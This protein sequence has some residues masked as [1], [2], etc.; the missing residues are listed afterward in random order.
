M[1]NTRV[2][3]FAVT[4]A[5]LTPETLAFAQQPSAHSK[6]AQAEAGGRFRKG[7]E[8]FD[9]GDY[10]AALIEFRRAYEIAPNFAVLYNIGQVYYLLQ[11]Y[12]NALNT[13]ERYLSEGD[14]SIQLARRRDVQKEIQKL[15]SRVASLDITV[16]VPDADVTIDD[17]TVGKSPLAKPVVVNPGRHRIA[18][19]KAGFNSTSKSI[20]VAS[21]D[22]PKL[23][24]ELTEQAKPTTPALPTA[25]PSLQG[26]GQ[27]A[28]A[29]GEVTVPPPPPGGGEVVPPSPPPP[30]K[31]SIPWVGWVITG[32][33]AAG[34]GVCGTVALLNSNDL[35]HRLVT[36]QTSREPIENAARGAKT[37]A[38][39]TDILT[40][41]AVVA[42][43]ISLVFTLKGGAK[44]AAPAAAMNRAQRL[45]PELR[46][47]VGPR[48][49]SVLGAF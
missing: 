4:L 22:A 41:A 37:F 26:N 21:A 2:L 43:G 8:L 25:D 24:F 17:V 48:G 35:K 13:L 36:P 16:N 30:V 11:D 15:Q 40:G 33:L 1:N 34:A 46:V 39:V 18:I 5:V 19:S 23:T 6:A 27:G 32:G 47:G 45:P 42:G 3:A 44:P 12:A 28:K 7:A 49:V 20:E 9:E 10:Q 29:G 38:L 31:R 14:K